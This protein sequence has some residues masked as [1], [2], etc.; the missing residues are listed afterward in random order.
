MSLE[1]GS[2]SAVDDAEGTERLWQEAA[3]LCSGPMLGSWWAQWLWKHRYAWWR[4]KE[5]F[6][7]TMQ[8]CFAHRP[9]RSGRAEDEGRTCAD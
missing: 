8:K 1:P 4:V 7:E 3:A 5:A 2:P 6:R 9:V